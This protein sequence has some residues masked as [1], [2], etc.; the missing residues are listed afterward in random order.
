MTDKEHD[1]TEIVIAICPSCGQRSTFKHLGTQI[2]PDEIAK[3]L[4]IA[5]RSELYL[6]DTCFSTISERNLLED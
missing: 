6:C 4:G 1:K 2:W 3:R 5:P